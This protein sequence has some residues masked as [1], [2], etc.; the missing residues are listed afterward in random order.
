MSVS[1]AQNGV[2]KNKDALCKRHMTEFG[3]ECA[4]NQGSHP[5]LW[6]GIVLEDGKE[7][8]SRKR[9]EDV[10]LYSGEYKIENRCKNLEQT[11]V[12]RV[13]ERREK[14]KIVRFR[15]DGQSSFDL[16]GRSLDGANGRLAASPM[17]EWQRNKKESQQDW[18]KNPK[19]RPEI[20][21]DGF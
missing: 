13:N 8:D 5:R 19:W 16:D 11:V 17:F 4:D 15:L 7:W 9:K 12:A 2:L 10:P 6:E 1:T 20:S 3:G 18:V 14:D 21:L